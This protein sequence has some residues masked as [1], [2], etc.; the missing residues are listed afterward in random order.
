VKEK[1]NKPP[2]IA[3][4]LLYYLVN[5]EEREFISG[6]LKE[7]YLEMFGSSGRL[8]ANLW[9]WGQIV[10]SFYHFLKDSNYWRIA[11]FKSYLK[12]AVRNLKRQK[13][14]TFIKISGLAI[15]LAVCILLL[16]YIWDELSFDRF[17][18]NADNIYRLIYYSNNSNQ[19]YPWVAP[20]VSQ[21]LLDNFPEIREATRILPRDGRMIKY[22]DDRF[23]EN[24][25]I[26]ADDSFFNIFSFELKSGNPE[27]VL[28]QPFSIVITESIAHKYFGNKNPIGEVFDVENENEYT[29][30]GVMS[31]I[32]ANSHFNCNFVATLVESDTVFGASW[33]QNW[34]WQ[35]FLVYGLFQ[36]N[37]SK[38]EFEKKC[39]ILLTEHLDPNDNNIPHYTLQRMKDIHLYSAHLGGDIRPQGDINYVLIF[40]GIGVLILLIACFNYIYLLTANAASRAVEVGIKK[41]I[42]ATRKQ[43]AGQFFSESIVVLFFAMFLS[44]IIVILCLPLFNALT[45]KLLSLTALLNIWII[46]G[47]IGMVLITGLISGSYPALVISAFQPVR[48]IKGIFG[49]GKSKF[50]FN[51]I[52]VVIQF[53]IS[54][55]LII[56]SAFMFRQMHF[57]RNRKLGFNKEHI[58]V[59]QNHERDNRQKYE[60][61]KNTLLQNNRILSVASASRVPSDDLNNGGGIWHEGLTDGIVIRIV[62]VDFDYFET[63][64]INTALYGRLFS[65]QL[66]TDVNDAI[67]LNE[68]CVRRLE[69]QQA[70]VGK[71]VRFGWPDSDRTI[72]GIVK[73]F[74]FE[75]LYEDF[76]P[77][78]FVIHYPMCSRIMVKIKSSDIHKTLAHIEETWKD[79]YPSWTYEYSFMDDRFEQI[80]HSEKRTFQLMGYFSLL[81]VF[82]ACLGLYGLASF[83]TKRRFKEIGVRKV[84]GASITQIIALLSRDFIK[85]VIIANIIAYPIAWYAMDKWFQHFA[86]HTELVWWIFALAGL[87]TIF[88]ALFTVSWQSFCAAARAP[89]DALKYE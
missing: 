62:H 77:T 69:L 70:P 1:K 65:A 58:V 24:D 67:I 19:S 32:P 48:V 83:T 44:F 20:Q 21:M 22:K 52:L 38:S 27:T 57:I 43:L 8:K 45:G 79:L 88:I 53:S 89:V 5:K 74:H 64:G 42:G 37:F 81:A 31:D 66:E 86:F 41:V 55:I 73:D 14:Y 61:F 36:D 17:H 87:C 51:R 63:I 85:W 30:T 6:D 2:R 47:I 29:I 23:K 49:F 15:G 9:Y 39:T 84:L 26:Y 80:Y 10:K 75:S 50:S 35:N 4:W 3:E 25:F 72:V 34:G 46:A 82:I 13:G 76:R 60:L 18:K 40:S 12:T 16:L 78:A 28:K 33:M 11:M 59:L 7:F 68:T 54:A 71:T 56:C